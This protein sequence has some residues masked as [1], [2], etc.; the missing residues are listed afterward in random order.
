MWIL[1]VI[2]FV[3]DLNEYKVTKFNTYNNRTQCEINQTVLKA[4]F[5]EDEKA[6]C[7]YE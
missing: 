4:L 5:E 7:V 3:P 6:V 2:S 1:F